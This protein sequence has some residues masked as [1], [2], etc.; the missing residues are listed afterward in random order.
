MIF[1]N[2]NREARAQAFESLVRP[3]VAVLYRSAL[4]FTRSPADAEDIVQD[5]LIKAYGHL[6]DLERVADLRP[7]LLRVLYREFVDARRKRVR[8]ARWEDE[9]ARAQVEATGGCISAEQEPGS[10]LERQRLSSNL[11]SALRG[12][13]PDQRALVTLHYIDGYSIE[14]LATVFDAPVGTLKAR[15][16]RTRA[17]LRDVLGMQPFPNGERV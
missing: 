15:I 16:H 12:L 14:E 9:A 11:D 7:W 13:E 17:K 4:R 1:G 8:R 5:V 6:G 3:H 2:P 10:A